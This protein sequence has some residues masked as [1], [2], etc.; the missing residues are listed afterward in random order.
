MDEPSSRVPKIYIWSFL[1][2]VVMVLALPFLV[3]STQVRQLIGSFAREDPLRIAQPVTYGNSGQIVATVDSESAIA[4]QL[5][6]IFSG[7]S[8]DSLPNTDKLLKSM[9]AMQLS[10]SKLSTSPG[11]ASLTGNSNTVADNSTRL[12]IPVTKKVMVLNFNPTIESQGNKKVTEVKNWND[13]KRLTEMQFLSL[14]KGASNNFVNYQIVNW[15][16]VDRIPVKKDG[17]Q[18]TDERYLQ[19][20]QE[21]E[22]CIAQYRIDRNATKLTQCINAS[23][24]HFPDS[25]DYL[26]ILDDFDVCE[27]RNANEI[28][29]LWL[30][31]G[32]Y[33]GLWE[34]T[35]TGP[36][37]FFYNSPPT[38][39]SSCQK[40][41]PIMGYNFEREIGVMLEN[42][43]HRVESVMKH[44]Y[45]SWQPNENHAWNKFTLLNKDAPGKAGC[46]NMHFTPASVYDYDW[47][48]T[49]TVKSNCDDWFNYPNLTGTSKDL[50][51]N[52]WPD[53]CDQALNP[54][55]IMYK[56]WWFSHLPHY[57]G[58][59]PDGKLNNWWAYVLDYENPPLSLDPSPTPSVRVTGTPGSGSLPT[60]TLIPTVPPGCYYQSVQCFA[61]PCP[62]T[63]VCPPTPT[64][65]GAGRFAAPTSTPGVTPLVTRP[66]STPIS[67]TPKPKR[68]QPPV[69]KASLSQLP[70]LKVKFTGT[71]S[72]YDPDYTDSV[73]LKISGLPEGFTYTC[74]KPSAISVTCTVTGTPQKRSFGIVRITAN[75]S[76]GGTSTI[77]SLMLAG[78]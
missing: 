16:D 70:R 5:H 57:T 30:W 28:D 65:S 26:K 33:Y 11:S 64:A 37:A 73:S 36:N 55:G 41:L 74:T 67:T 52:A 2:V 14:I 17:F 24:C 58:I 66:S 61:A 31:G 10:A 50:N 25:V 72:A 59:A 78:F 75:D 49:A 7:T 35:L 39:G 68:N 60:P 4:D 32:P 19:C 6:Y 38:T 63:L 43:G 47:W 48:N 46:G 56:L 15:Q 9:S 34:S 71:I 77:S 13:P 51:C 1:P 42:Y 29:E 21:S 54:S 23:V 45:G 76:R 8:Q 12:P 22:A 40:Q 53:G 27:K 69:L 18:Y 44:V 3:K 20:T 62:Q